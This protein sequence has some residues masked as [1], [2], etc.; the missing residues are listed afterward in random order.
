M[1]IRSGIPIFSGLDFEKGEQR[2]LNDKVKTTDVIS[3]CLV[4]IFFFS[5]SL[6]PFILPVWALLLINRT[7]LRSRKI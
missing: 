3:L 2:F 4:V 6:L 7:H 1:I 5:L